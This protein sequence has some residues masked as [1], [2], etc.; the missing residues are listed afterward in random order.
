[1]TTLNQCPEVIGLCFTRGDAPT[2]NFTFKDKATGALIDI[3]GYTFLL[4]ADPEEDPID[5]ANNLWQLTG[6][7]IGAGINGKVQFALTSSQTD[8]LPAV[9]YYDVQWIDGSGD[10]RTVIK[11]PIEFKQDITK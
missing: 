11:G 6:A 7:I 4:T 2:F 8:Q 5:G 9:Y 3:T 1:M 10:I